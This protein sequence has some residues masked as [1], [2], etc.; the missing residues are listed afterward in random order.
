MSGGGGKV[1][2]TPLQRAQAD[3]AVT[4]WND[5]RSRWAPVRNFA[6]QR[7]QNVDPKRATALG[8]QN[9]ETQG[10]FGDASKK[11]DASLS[12]QG[13]SNNSGRSIMA[14]AGLSASKATSL[15][16]G[17]VDTNAAITR[18]YVGGL[19]D[20]I[21]AGQGQKAQAQAGMETLARNSGAQAAADA[22]AA[23][24]N[25]AG[26]GEAI[27]TGVGI[28]GGYGLSG[29][30]DG[31]NKTPDVNAAQAPVTYGPVDSRGLVRR[32]DGFVLNAPGGP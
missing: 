6:I 25:A 26:L 3:M 23:A 5:Y 13:L 21:S 1:K 18:Q 10:R 28:A 2:E 12:N 30:M 4:G 17:A 31:L 7:T 20:I 15:G 8:L 14:K 24:Q 29:Y 27:G 22:Q 32:S 9:V 19:Q 16:N 11:L